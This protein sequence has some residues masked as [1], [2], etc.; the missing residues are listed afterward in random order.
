[1]DDALEEQI[2]TNLS[3]SIISNVLSMFELRIFFSCTRHNNIIKNSEHNRS[4][5]QGLVES[6]VDELYPC[7]YMEAVL[8]KTNLWYMIIINHINTIIVTF[9]KQ[10]INQFQTII[11]VTCLRDMTLQTQVLSASQLIQN[12]KCLTMNI[13]NWCDRK[14]WDLL[15]SSASAKS[16]FRK[17]FR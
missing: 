9:F 17:K 10:Y 13:Q 5:Q 12:L 8:T 3:F 2:K 11:I 16:D 4:R 15:H 1:M 7:S 6:V 14:P